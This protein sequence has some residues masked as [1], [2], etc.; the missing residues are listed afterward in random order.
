MITLMRV[1][2]ILNMVSD[3]RQDILKSGADGSNVVRMK[4]TKDDLLAF[5]M[6]NS[7]FNHRFL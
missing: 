3:K 5:I 2:I 4:D 7:T 1:A 6:L